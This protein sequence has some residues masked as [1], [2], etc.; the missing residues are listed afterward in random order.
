MKVNSIRFGEDE[1]PNEIT[2]TMSAAEAA[3]VTK[4][5]GSL[6]PADINPKRFGTLSDLYYTLVD[7]MFNAYWDNGVEDYEDGGGSHC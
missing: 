4:Y 7:K 3:D 2:V 6:I 1:L 5:I